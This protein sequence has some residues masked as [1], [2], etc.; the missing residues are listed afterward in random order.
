MANRKRK[1][2]KV[3]VGALVWVKSETLLPGNC[4]KLNAK[5]KGPHQVIEIIRKG[6]VYV[7]ESPY[8]GKCVQRAAEKV[9]PY[10]SRHEIIPEAK[11]LVD[12]DSLKEEEDQ[13]R[14]PR[15]RQPP[16]RYIEEC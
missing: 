5:W 9:K 3:H 11:E 2:E 15:H 6:Q 13:G 10:I 8:S 4:A 14:P 12:F 7:L 1:A 16:R